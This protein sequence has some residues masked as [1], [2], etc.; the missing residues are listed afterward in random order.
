[1]QS[2]PKTHDNTVRKIPH[3][4]H[5]YPRHGRG[6]LF[7]FMSPI[8]YQ[9]QELIESIMEHSPIGILVLWAKRKDQIEI[10]DGQQRVTTIIAFLE[11]EFCTVSGKK[12]S[13]LDDTEQVQFKAYDLFSLELEQSLS[14]D[15]ISTVFIRLQEGTIPANKISGDCKIFFPRAGLCSFQMV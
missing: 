4:Q 2:R 7:N 13:E 15:Q 10:L 14:P 9:K 11:D 12:F 1:M 3:H 8:S 6:V 5:N